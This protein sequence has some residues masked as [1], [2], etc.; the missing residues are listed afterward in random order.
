MRQVGVD[1][2]FHRANRWR[3]RIGG[4]DPGQKKFAFTLSD[5]RGAQG[6]RTAE[7]RFTSRDGAVTIDPRAIGCWRSRAAAG[8]GVPEGTVLTWDRQFASSAT[9]APTAL[10]PRR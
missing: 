10:I 3:L 8:H 7:A 9:C 6:G 4:L 2:F 5:A 1:P